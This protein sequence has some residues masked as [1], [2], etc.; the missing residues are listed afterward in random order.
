MPVSGETIR[1]GMVSSGPACSV[2]LNLT[3]HVMLIID[4]T[5]AYGCT[6]DFI[7]NS[8][9]FEPPDLVLAC[10]LPRNNYGSPIS[11]VSVVRQVNVDIGVVDEDSV[12]DHK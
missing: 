10:P 4:Q 12:F 11:R 6:I 1:P 3:A 2:R 5:T 9:L 8:N 7:I